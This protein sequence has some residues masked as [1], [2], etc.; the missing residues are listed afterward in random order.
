MQSKQQ[1]GVTLIELMIVLAIAAILTAVAAPSFSSLINSMRQTS[2]LTK[3]TG[4]LNRARGEAIKR[5]QRILVC[6]RGTDT[7]CGAGGNNINW[8]NGWLVCYDGNQDGVCDLNNTT[9]PNPIIVQPAIHSTLGLTGTS[10]IRFNPSGTQGANGATT[11]TLALE[12][13]WAGAVNQSTR[14]AATGHISKTP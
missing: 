5:N 6:V 1:S 8:Q 9:N 10:P 11:A 4:D 13:T 12:G 2:V 7:V 3:L 14:I